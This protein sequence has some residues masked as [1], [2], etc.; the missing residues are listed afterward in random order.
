MKKENQDSNESTREEYVAPN[1]MRL[2]FDAYDMTMFSN[3]GDVGFFRED[4]DDA[5]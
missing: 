3:D 5:F 4:S 1:Y 2:V